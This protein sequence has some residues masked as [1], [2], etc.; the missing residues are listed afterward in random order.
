MHASGLRHMGLSPETMR[1]DNVVMLIPGAQ[2]PYGF[3]LRD[4]RIHGLLS[5]NVMSMKLCIAKLS[6]ILDSSSNDLYR[7]KFLYNE[8][9]IC[10][11][12]WTHKP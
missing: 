9:I 4:M 2:V 3:L 8:V 10:K 1:L 6:R 12:T 5:T 11:R 7:I